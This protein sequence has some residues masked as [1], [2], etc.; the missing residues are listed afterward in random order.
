MKLTTPSAL[1]RNL[2]KLIFGVWLIA[3]ALVEK[4]NFGSPGMS[5]FLGVVILAAGVCTLLGK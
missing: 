4:F 5:V 2:G 1:P 3:M